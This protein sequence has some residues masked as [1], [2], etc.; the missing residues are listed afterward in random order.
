MQ[1][2]HQKP[3]SQKFQAA[4][5]A[6]V[7][8]G[9]LPVAAV[10]AIFDLSSGEILAARAL[11]IEEGM[12]SPDAPPI[13]PELQKALADYA[14]QNGIERDALAIAA[15]MKERAKARFRTDFPPGIEKAVV[16]SVK[17]TLLDP[18]TAHVTLWYWFPDKDVSGDIVVCGSVNAK[19]AFGG[20]AG[21]IPFYSTVLGVAAPPLAIASVD[22]PQNDMSGAH[23][24]FGVSFK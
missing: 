10:A 2:S 14:D 13:G 12:M 22:D 9:A 17:A 15:N 8:F 21:E 20:Y 6:A 7:C 16:D 3:R 24:K 4:I 5:L 1:A 23:C 11:L 18:Y 19:N